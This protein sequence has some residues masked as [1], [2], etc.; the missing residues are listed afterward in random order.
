MAPKAAAKLA[1]QAA[2]A[3][4]IVSAVGLVRLYRTTPELREPRHEIIWHL[5]P[6]GALLLLALAQ[7]ALLAAPRQGKP[8]AKPNEQPY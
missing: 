1:V 8:A 7:L 2:V 6:L 3:L 5:I 4:T